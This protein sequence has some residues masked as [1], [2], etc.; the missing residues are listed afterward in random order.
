MTSTRFCMIFGLIAG[1]AFIAASAILGALLPNYD[2]VTQTI[3]EIGES[4]SPFETIFKAINLLV[5]V[6]FIVF[7]FGVYR[8][9]RERRVS[10]VPASLLGYFA[11]TQ[12]GVFAFESPHP[13]HN[14]FGIS[15]ILGFFAPLA[16]AITWPVM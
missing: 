1:A 16:L 11:V 13:L 3:S 15:S 7:A 5:A 6:C 12:L 9:S 14:L 10:L 2:P 4:G 8:I